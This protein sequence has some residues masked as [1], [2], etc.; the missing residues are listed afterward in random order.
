VK[1]VGFEETVGA[2]VDQHYLFDFAEGKA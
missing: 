2:V 1:I